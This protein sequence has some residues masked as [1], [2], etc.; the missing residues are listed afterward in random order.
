V[1][2]IGVDPG[3][4]GGLAVVEM[5]DGAVPVL[6]EATDI[7]IIGTGAK[8]RVDV[9]AVRDSIAQHRPALAMI[10][11][12]GVMPKQ[13]IASGFKFGRA[14]GSIEATVMLCGIPVE[15]VEPSVWKTFWKLPGKNKEAARQK[16][17]LQ[18]PTS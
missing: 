17:L 15:I 3:I 1:R 14:C 18:F 5:I 8:E 6:V 12:A 4:A 10:E 9:V 16:A 2:V 7:P 13:G 11:R